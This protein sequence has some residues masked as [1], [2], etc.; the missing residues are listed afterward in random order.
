MSELDHL[1]NYP[2]MYVGDTETPTRLLEEVLD[3]TLD[4]TQ[5]GWGDTIGIFIDT[6]NKTFRI[7]DNGRGFPFNKDL[8][9]EKDPP[10]LALTKMF[11]SAK[12]NKGKEDSSY[13]LA[14]GLHGIGLVACYALSEW[15]T[16]DIYRD[17]MHAKYYLDKHGKIEREFVEY[18][19][20]TKVPYSTRIEL[21]P[22]KKYFSSLDINLDTVKQRL[23]IAS[24]NYPNLKIILKVDNKTEVVSNITIDDLVKKY[25]SSND[26]IA[27]YDFNY[28]NKKKEYFNVRF[29]WD[30]SVL[31][32]KV[33]TSVN[34]CKV[35]EGAHINKVINVLK[36]VLYDYNG[37]VS[38]NTNVKYN[39]LQSDILVGL[40]LYINL[41]VIKASYAEQIKKRLS[42]QSDI[43]VLDSF[44]TMLTK[45][46]KEHQEELYN[47][48]D[49]IQSYRNLQNTKSLGKAV[50][51][52][53]RGSHTYTKLRDCIEDN[54]ELII[55]E[56]DSAGG[57]LIKVRDPKK[58]AILPLRGVVPNALVKTNIHE[59]K[60][61][62]DII[63]A[64]GC[65]T[66]EHC[67][68]NKLRYDKIII[69]CDADPAGHWIT[70]L[71]ITFFAYKMSNLV[72][73]GKVFVCQTPLFGYKE[74]GEFVP[75][76]TEED[77]KTAR[78]EKRKIMRFKGLGEFDSQDLKVFTIGDKRKLIP[79]DWPADPQK[80]FDLMSKSEERKKLV[81]SEEEGV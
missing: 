63:T 6:K 40:K 77:L 55:C 43:F 5:S 44:E 3:N 11:T 33:F 19:V 75:L 8:P 36:K 7:L 21:K 65:G 47:I 68:A 12:F 42:S 31:A 70:A 71:L 32:T 69:A 30:R 26:N 66:D 37:T 18:D 45:Y 50:N 80:I 46:F 81:L 2:G 39:F 51:L 9:L 49:E 24:V 79:V 13:H 28:E 62:R 14:A 20:N 61:L 41:R 56:G 53:K 25:L 57:G 15:I 29:A 48:L 54:G 4:E 1:R 22:D 17:G 23:D 74:K 76:W 58:H 72:K 10:I 34:L 60:E 38:K 35:D 27:W 52:N 73:N 16:V 64:C 59:N 67:N 78:D